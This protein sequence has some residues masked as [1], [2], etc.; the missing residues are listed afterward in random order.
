MVKYMR[1]IRRL[2]LPL[3]LLLSVPLQAAEPDLTQMQQQAEQGDA[4]AQLNLGAAYDNGLGVEQNVEQARH[5]YQK[6]AEQGLAEAQF[7]LAHL[8]VT[9]EEQSALA[10][11]WML[12]AAKQGMADAQYLMGVTYAE[13]IGVEENEEKAIA[14]LQ[15]AIAQGHEDAATFLKQSYHLE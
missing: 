11:E 1:S 7:N 3:I 2:L 6:A 15:K 9:E 5:W 12:K 8:L 13:G 4:W 14:W 10:A